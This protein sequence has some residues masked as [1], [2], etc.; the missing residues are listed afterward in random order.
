MKRLLISGIAA[1]LVASGAFLWVQENS[2]PENSIVKVEKDLGAGN[3]GT[4]TFYH[5]HL[6][7]GSE[8]NY[9][10]YRSHHPL[11]PENPE[12]CGEDSKD[13]GWDEVN[14]TVNSEAFRR[15]ESETGMEFVP[16]E[17][18]CMESRTS[19]VSC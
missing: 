17:S 12:K 6:K 1:A 4:H 15:T 16:Q 9:D 2:A 8:I 10:Y 7:N 18:I 5:V 3:M 14:Q 19:Y 13:S 11:C